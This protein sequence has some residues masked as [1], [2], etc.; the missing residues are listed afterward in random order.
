MKRGLLLFII[1]AGVSA[2]YAAPSFAETQTSERAMSAVHR[3]TEFLSKAQSFSV[4]ADIGYDAVQSS[5][6]KIEFGETRAITVKRPDRLLVEETKRNGSKSR[7]TY[8]GSDLSLYH[9]SENVYAVESKPGTLDEA[10]GYFIHDLGMRFPLAEMLSS[11]LPEVIAQRAQD[12]A[13]VEESSIGGVACDHIALRADEV[14]LQLWIAKNGDPL[15]LRA[16]I[17][18][19]RLDGRPQFWAQFS[20]WNLSPKTDNALFSFTPPADASKIAFSPKNTA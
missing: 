10:I 14:D 17:T 3:M 16:V 4:T 19:K 7:L 2:V 13:Y 9:A 12:A 1:A 8:D 18:Y 15:P 6:Q 11:R 5:G 20:Q